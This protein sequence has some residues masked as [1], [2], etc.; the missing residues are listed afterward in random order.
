[1]HFLV[2]KSFSRLRRRERDCIQFYS[3]KENYKKIWYSW[4]YLS[5]VLFNQKYFNCFHGIFLIEILHIF[6]ISI[7]TQ[8][9]LGTLTVFRMN[10]LL[11]FEALFWPPMGNKCLLFA[12]INSLIA[13]LCLNL[14]SVKMVSTAD[15]PAKNVKIY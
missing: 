6:V 13:T 1:M 7:L 14:S 8:D 11:L 5:F 9:I 3:S 4:R 12:L 15:T 10:G 2:Q